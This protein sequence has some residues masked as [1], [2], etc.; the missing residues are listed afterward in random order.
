MEKVYIGTSYSTKCYI[1]Q[2]IADGQKGTVYEND[3]C[4]HQSEQT[5]YL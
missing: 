4:E 2:L 1:E 3:Q 5:D